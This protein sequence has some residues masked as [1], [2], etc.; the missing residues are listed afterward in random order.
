MMKVLLP[1]DDLQ[2][3]DRIRIRQL[4]LN[5]PSF[6]D[7]MLVLFVVVVTIVVVVA[8]A[9]PPGIGAGFKDIIF[10]AD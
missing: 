2:M 1:L 9:E 10:L 7:P 3:V 8:K 4:L 5:N 6:Q